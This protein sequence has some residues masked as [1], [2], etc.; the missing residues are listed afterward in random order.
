[1]YIEMTG[2]LGA[3]RN[4][5]VPAKKKLYF[6][7]NNTSGGF[8]VTVKVSGQT[9]ISVPNGRKVVL[10]CNGTDIVDCLNYF[11]GL[12]ATPIGQTSPAAGSFTTLTASNTV[13]GAGFSTFLASPPAIGGSTPAA[14]SFSTLAASNT[15]SGT[16]FSNL[17]ASPTGI[18]SST[19]STGA[20]TTLSAS[21]TVGGGGFT[22]FLAS[23]TGPIGTTT[24]VGGRFAFAHTAPIAVTFSATA[25]QIDCSL[26]NVFTV[27]MT[28][29]VSVAPTISNPKDGQTINW[30]ITQSSAG[31]YTMVW[32]TSFKW[33]GGIAGALTLGST[34]AVDLVVATYRSSTSFWYVSL[35]KNFS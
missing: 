1:M 29:N 35:L 23:P 2:A 10:V 15:V 22:S 20:F 24:P 31:S 33:P 12:N 17:L 14:G 27:I 11:S 4:L 21:S 9:G 6:I 19:P 34:T 13:S 26:S 5:L 7:F 18:G 3:A 28:A 30:F 32:S 16:G 8:A 25:M